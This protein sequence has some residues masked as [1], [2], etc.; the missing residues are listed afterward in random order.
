MFATSITQFALLPLLHPL[1]C[2]PLS[3]ACW[4]YPTPRLL[5]HTAQ[6]LVSR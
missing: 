6:I 5:I 2:L 4:P 1:F 3:I